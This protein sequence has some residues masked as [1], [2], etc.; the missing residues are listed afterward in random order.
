[1][2]DSEIFTALT[3][4]IHYFLKWVFISVLTG[5]LGG[6]CG[7]LFS[8]GVSW[9][10]SFRMSHEWMLFFMPLSGLLIVWLYHAFREDKNRGTNMIL[11]SIS[12]GGDVTPATG[13]LIF[14]STI[15]THVTGGSSG[16]EGAALQIGGCI[17]AR[18][19]GLMKLDEKDR[20]VAVMCGMSSVFSALF[21]TPVA[22]AIFSMEVIS[23]GVLYYAA[24][25]PCIFAA[26]AGCWVAALFG[27][28]GEHF[29]LPYIP[30]I[31]LSGA[32]YMVVLGIL[33]ALVSILLCYVLHG[34]ERLY[35][36]IFP[37]PY[38]RI[39]A[40]SAIFIGAALLIG[41]R[42]YCGSSM[43]LIEA[44]VG[45][46]RVRYYD[47]L[48]KML[49]TAIALGGGFKGG[50]IVPTLCVGATF[51]SAVGML[52]GF[53]P[54]LSAACGMTAL[55]AGVTNCPISSLIIALEMFGF[56][57]MGY[58]SIIIAVSFALSG[59]CGLYSSQRFPYSKTKAEYIN[60]KPN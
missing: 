50:E 43:G 39:L 47:F 51:G 4:S 15:L 36:R 48:L 56:E 38:V 32:V 54:S 16:R 9:A 27:L 44:S 20:Q 53:S 60:R 13:P 29:S 30:A 49:F 33:C 6:L 10:T 31:S 7:S 17:G 24:L 5:C 21:G 46:E 37:N 55:F 34:A 19:S 28:T 8:L 12:D 11:E 23:V 41:T 2:K 57:G 52:T 35:K 18:M 26:Y 1:M 3:Q 14:V 25:V 45:G 42:D 58:F 59:Y 40:A 22:A